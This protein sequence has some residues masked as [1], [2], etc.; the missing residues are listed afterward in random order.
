MYWLD[1][2]GSVYEPPFRVL[3]DDWGMAV[4]Y[5]MVVTI[6]DHVPKVGQIMRKK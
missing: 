5:E 1:Q 2:D 4:R 3:N 6:L